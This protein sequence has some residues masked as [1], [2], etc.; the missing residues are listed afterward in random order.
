M[1]QADNTLAVR[2]AMTA[3]QSSSRARATILSPAAPP[4]ATMT[5]SEGSMPSLTVMSLMALIMVS[6]ETAKIE[7]AASSTL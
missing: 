4:P 1:P 6:F 2:G 7:Y 3:R 5:A